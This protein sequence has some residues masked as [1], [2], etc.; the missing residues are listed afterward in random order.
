[1]G[2]AMP[3]KT[4]PSP[5]DKFTRHHFL[6]VLGKRIG[7]VCD[8]EA[9]ARRKTARAKSTGESVTNETGSFMY[10]FECT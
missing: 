3:P 7:G 5:H 10:V 2:A 1:M 4:P 9:A 6:R 8:S